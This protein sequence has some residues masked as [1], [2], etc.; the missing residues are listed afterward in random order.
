MK[1]NGP[2]EAHPALVLYD[3]D[4]GVEVKGAATRSLA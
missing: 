2:P 3:N 4:S 1:T